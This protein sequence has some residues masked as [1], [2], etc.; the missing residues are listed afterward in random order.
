[1]NQ[2]CRSNVG[3]VGETI[4]IGGEG[5]LRDTIDEYFPL[6]VGVGNIDIVVERTESGNYKKSIKTCEFHIAEEARQHTD[7]IGQI[8]KKGIFT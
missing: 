1:M 7:V 2:I 4:A 8:S 5:V 6:G 3:A